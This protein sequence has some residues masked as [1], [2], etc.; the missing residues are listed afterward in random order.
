MT[1][2]QGKI[3]VKGIII[4]LTFFIIAIV[5]II[6]GVYLSYT[7]SPKKIVGETL[8]SMSNTIKQ[9][10][11]KDESLLLGNNYTIDSNIKITSKIDE[12]NEDIAYY[13]DFL[14]NLASLNTNVTISQDLDNN[15]MLFTINSKKN[16]NEFI[17]LKYLIKDSTGYYYNK[18]VTNKY[19]NVGTNNYFETLSKNVN[20]RDNINYLT[21]F[22]IDSVN[23]NI[24]ENYISTHNERIEY[25]DNYINATKT[26][27]E[28]DNKK[29][30]NIYKAVIKDLKEDEK[31]SSILENY[32]EGF[33]KSK[34][35]NNY[36][37][38]DKK[39]FLI[40]DIYTTGLTNKFV[41]LEITDKNEY[42]YSKEPTE[43][44]MCYEKIDN[45]NSKL[46]MINKNQLLYELNINK[47]N[48]NYYKINILNENNKEIG[49]ITYNKT[50]KETIIDLSTITDDERVDIDY[51]VNYKEIK[52]NSY[53][54]DINLDIKYLKDNKNIITINTIANNKITKEVNIKEDTSDSILE[55]SLTEEQQQKK[56]E[57][58]MNKLYELMGGI[59]ERK[60]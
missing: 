30:N 35:K 48:D 55:K 14:K 6:L 15:K 45:K 1:N 56:D 18:S 19:I 40:I 27:V 38:L 52:K 22:I 16:N 54:E 34:I 20:T 17:D 47:E 53:K 5:C 60:K 50:D 44:K 46:Y 58:I 4:I 41:K 28:L 33:K 32:H 2:N 26:T 57:Y 42:E 3:S 10:T 43:S 31:A 49:N 24:T 25:N 39:E 29:L 21:T 13:K 37:L 9:L 8:T 59:Y 11:E 23:K 12:S 7:S 36:E 51:K